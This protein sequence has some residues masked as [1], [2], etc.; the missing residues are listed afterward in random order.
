MRWF[1][2][3][4]L[5]SSFAFA[6]S[7]AELEVLRLTNQFRAEN[8]LKPLQWD[9]LAYKA[10]LGHAK[11]MLSRNFFAHVN[12]DGA[13][14]AVRMRAVGV[15]E[16]NTGENLAQFENYPDAEIAARSVDG[17]IHSPHHRDNLLRPE[18]THLGVS[19]VRK[20]S[21]VVA[22]QNFLGRP[23]ELSL[24]AQPVQAPRSVLVLKGTAPGTLGV[25]VG[26]GIFTKLNSPIDARLELPPGAKVNYA[27][28]DGKAWWDVGLNEQGVRVQARLESGVGV[29]KRFLFMLPAGNFTLAVGKE[30]RAW[31]DITGPVPMDLSLP[32]TLETLWIGQRLDSQIRYIFRIPLVP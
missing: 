20:G 2:I 13:D 19:I 29:G 25:F 21:I 3:V 27:L 16:V 15:I 17:W 6:Q 31:R 23:F 1:A 18:Y 5:L 32:G 9:N 12:P 24:S 14:S 10:A 26:P 7:P 4:L 30:P 22:V 28:Y 11:D 8:G